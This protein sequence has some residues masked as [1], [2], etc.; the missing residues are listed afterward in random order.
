MQGQ[1]NRKKKKK[2]KKH[3]SQL[4][5]YYSYN[6]CINYPL[7]HKD[8]ELPEWP[9]ENTTKTT[10]RTSG[11]MIHPA[12]HGYHFAPTGRVPNKVDTKAVNN[13]YS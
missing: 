10:V 7:K 6:M 3:L 2:K 5:S 1:L 12:H 9:L 11:M 13:T 8:L 4:I